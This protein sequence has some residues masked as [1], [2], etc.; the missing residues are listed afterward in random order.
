MASTL[1]D[2]NDREICAAARRESALGP[3]QQ[4]FSCIASSLLLLGRTWP[5]MISFG[6]LPQSGYDSTSASQGP[7]GPPVRYARPSG[8]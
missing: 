3:T 8:P 6:D 5:C 7:Q 4:T 2:G 1:S